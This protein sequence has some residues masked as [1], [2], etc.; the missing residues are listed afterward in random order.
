[1]SQLRK[2]QRNVERQTNGEAPTTNVPVNHRDLPVGKLLSPPIKGDFLA[3]PLF[4]WVATRAGDRVPL[5]ML[6]LLLMRSLED[7]RPC[8]TLEVT[9]PFI[10]TTEL[11]TYGALERFG[12]DGRVWPIDEG[13]PSGDAV[14]EAQVRALM[15]QARLRTTLTFPP[16]DKGAALQSVTVSRAQGP[17]LMPPLPEHQGLV[18]PDKMARLRDLCADPST[19]LLSPRS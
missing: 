6:T 4:G 5:V 9:L 12:W 8:G 17:F 11:A 15:E 7:P 18:D 19:M 16:N 1:M 13:W 14:E 2:L 10:E 3:L